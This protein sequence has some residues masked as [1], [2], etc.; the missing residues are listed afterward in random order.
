M[1]QRNDHLKQTL[2]NQYSRLSHTSGF[3]L[4]EKLQ[5]IEWWDKEQYR[6]KVQNTVS[7]IGSF[8]VFLGCCLVLIFTSFNGSHFRETSSVPIISFAASIFA[9]II[10]QKVQ[11]EVKEKIRVFEL[12]Q[13]VFNNEKSEVGLAI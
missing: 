5:N 4:T 9:L 7:V 10:T 1:E 12:L 2:I 8:L 3:T 6:L 13:I 11:S